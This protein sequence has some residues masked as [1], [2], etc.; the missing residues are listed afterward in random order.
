MTA[1]ATRCALLGAM[2]SLAA[3]ASVAAEAPSE[4]PT[5]DTGMPD[6]KPLLVERMERERE[7]QRSR[8]V[9]IGHK[10]NYLLPVTYNTRP[11]NAPFAASDSD[12]LQG[13]RLDR[14]EAT[15]QISLKFTLADNLLTD[16]DEVVFGFTAKS[17]WQVYNQDISAPFRETNYEPELFW[18]T[19]IKWTPLGADA[20]LLAFGLSHES[21]GRSGDLSR[22]WNR[23][24]A[25]LVLE[26]KRF[27]FSLKP[28][29]R[30]PES[31][32]S[33]PTD[34]SGD[35]NPDI[36]KFMGHFEFRTLY[37]RKDNEFGVML[38]NNLRSSNKGAVQLDWTFPL[39]RSVRGYAQYFNGYGESL[40]DY[41][42]KVE[43]FGIGI[44]LTDLL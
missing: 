25:D 8:S 17:F 40:I 18:V 24:Y 5:T 31:A 21:N 4:A 36:E 20:S 3:G 38:R 6:E 23:V 12:V 43:R 35:D 14:W 32:K 19:P 33:S 15:F 22:S 2:L 10:R 30:I 26:K 13:E 7:A 34:P 39:W 11:N 28:W 37:R 9:L 16:D 41:N 1:V 27:V 29:W 44:L 42:A